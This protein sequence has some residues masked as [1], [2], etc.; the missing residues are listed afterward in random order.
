M[1]LVCFA[2]I[3]TAMWAQTTEYTF[4]VEIISEN[5][6][7]N[8]AS[9][10]PLF[11][12]DIPQ[13]T[14]EL[15]L[16]Y[17]P[18]KKKLDPIIIRIPDDKKKE[19]TIV[20]PDKGLIYL[21]EN[22]DATIVI[23]IHKSSIIEKATKEYDV[24]YKRAMA[25][26][27]LVNTNIDSLKKTNLSLDKK[28]SA[29]Q[30]SILLVIATNY[31]VSADNL[32]TATALLEGQDKYFLPITAGLES[33]L[34]EAED[35]KEIFRNLV[36]INLSI[37]NVAAFNALDSTMTVYNK[38]YN[39]LNSNNADYE[40]AIAGYWKSDALADLYHNIVDYA[41]NNI[42]RT[43]IFPLNDA[44]IKKINIYVH[45][46]DKKARNNLRLEITK[47]INDLLPNLSNNLGVLDVK[48]KTF[49]TRL[50]SEKSAFN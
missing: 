17:L 33:Y 20:A 44:I 48:V 39:S 4:R 18:F 45:E 19:Y 24:Q 32:R 46:N 41:L 49:N 13:K 43:Y 26:L 36:E 10:F 50:Q 5:N 12:D 23:K 8:T 6:E 34:N 47:N 35:L 31:K 21:P 30:D 42:H 9:F 28:I 16:I 27:D 7:S 1:M 25:K 2:F 29:L 14:N 15:G 22:A 11:F 40:R 3:K 38:F 37:G